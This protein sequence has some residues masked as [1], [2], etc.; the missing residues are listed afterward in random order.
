MVKECALARLNGRKKQPGE[1]KQR[2]SGWWIIA[3]ILSVIFLSW[4]LKDWDN[5]RWIMAQAR[6]IVEQ[7]NEREKEQDNA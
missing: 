5:S 3:F 1:R 7:E 4:L 6:S 2:M